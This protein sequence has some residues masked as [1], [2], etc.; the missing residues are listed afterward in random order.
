MKNYN[1][2]KMVFNFLFVLGW[3]VVLLG[4]VSFIASLGDDFI[5]ALSFGGSICT[6]GIINITI[7]QIG[8][9]QIDTAENTYELTQLFKQFL[10]QTVVKATPSSGLDHLPEDKL[11]SGGA[12]KTYKG[13]RIEYGA[14]KSEFL[15]EG[16]KF[17][18]IFAA[19]KHID[20]LRK[21]E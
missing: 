16:V 12:V 17:M 2:A 13:Y 14:G 9:A 10:T 6:V 1:T 8:L 21:S 18:G 20:A 15:V 3:I 4:A 11:V 5:T 19:E 7:A